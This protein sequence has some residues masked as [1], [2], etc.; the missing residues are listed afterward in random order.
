MPSVFRWLR[1]A[2]VLALLAAALVVPAEAQATCTNAKANPNDVSVAAAKKATLC[3]LNR[4]R[5]SKGLRPFRHNRR[6]SR[7]SQRHARAMVRRHFFA[8][9]N[10]VSRIKSARYLRAARGWTVGENIAWGAWELATPKSIVRAWMDSPGHRANI[11]SHGFREIGIGLKR[12]APVRG[13]DRAA[14][15]V[16]DFGARR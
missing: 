16:T 10:F 4:I 13:M 2:L 1:V 6:L 9:G 3:L 5:R 12:G 8:H 14:T 15:Y 11:L 7:A